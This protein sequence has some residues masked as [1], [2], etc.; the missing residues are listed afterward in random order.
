MKFPGSFSRGNRKVFFFRTWNLSGL[1]SILLIE[2]KGF[3]K[4]RRAV[5]FQGESVLGKRRS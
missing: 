5:C 4:K 3:P 1:A 2:K